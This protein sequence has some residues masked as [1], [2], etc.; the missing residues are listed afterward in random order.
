M[1]TRD[2]GTYTITG[3]EN[4][5]ASISYIGTNVF[6]MVM[7]IMGKLTNSISKSI[8]RAQLQIDI[9]TGMM[10]RKITEEDATIYSGDSDKPLQ[11]TNKSTTTIKV[12]LIR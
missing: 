12:K 8:V 1:D 10:L 5:I 6:S 7:N 2:S 9:N 3:I 11:S 4:G